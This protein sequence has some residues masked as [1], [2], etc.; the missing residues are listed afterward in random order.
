MGVPPW[1]GLAVWALGRKLHELACAG[2]HGH[3]GWVSSH[4]LA[5]MGV[6]AMSSHVLAG[7]GWRLGAGSS[8]SV[9]LVWL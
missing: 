8:L 6:E 9:A 5:G 3:G 1:L 2:W 4:V 7:M